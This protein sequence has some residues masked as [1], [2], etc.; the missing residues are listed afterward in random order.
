M[1]GR[2]RITIAGAG[3]LGSVLATCLHRAGYAIDEIVFHNSR[4]ARRKAGVLARS[5]DARAVDVAGANLEAEVF[6]FCVPDDAI[7]EVAQSLA[8]KTNWKGRIA[9]HSS[10]A[11]SSEELTALKRR[12]AHVASVHPMMT[13]VAGSKPSLAG[14]P[15]AIEGDA[16][17]VRVSRRMVKDLGGQAYAIR[18]Q[19]KVAYHAWGTFASPLLTALLATTEQVAAAA[20][21]NR[22][23]AKRR[24][25]PILQQTLANYAA[26]NAA[27]AFSGPIVRGDAETIRRHLR[28]L[29]KVPGAGE[30]YVALARAAVRYLPGKRKGQVQRLLQG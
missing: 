4:A 14:V 1:R 23:E 13:F 25:L 5:V 15:W 26:L 9:L 20:G 30:V 18:K 22:K 16:V 28:S 12:G 24:M 21:V 6:W 2:L 27:G 3:N 10:G 17:A 8:E 7:A 11:L 29:R 19:E